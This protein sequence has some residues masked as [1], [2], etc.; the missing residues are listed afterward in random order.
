MSYFQGCFSFTVAVAFF[1]IFTECFFG[2]VMPK[3]SNGAG[4]EGE[5]QFEVK[6]PSLVEK[7]SVFTTDKRQP[8]DETSDL[9]KKV[10]VVN[11]GPNGMLCSAQLIGPNLVLT[12]AHCIVDASSNVSTDFI[13]YAGYNSGKFI[14][15][16]K[17]IKAWVGTT[18]PVTVSGQPL[19][20]AILKIEERLGD[21]FG[22]F[23]FHQYHGSEWSMYDRLRNEISLVAHHNDKAQGRSAIIERGCGSRLMYGGLIRHT[24]SMTMGSSGGALLLTHKDQQSGKMV[25]RIVALN[26]AGENDSIPREFDF[27]IANAAIPAS[28]FQ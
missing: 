17:V 12:A 10:G 6:L 20:W 22:W 26:I 16:S 11:G 7:I 27:K 15:K 8:L 25:E 3:I 9:F 23:E 4:G 18:M 2:R 5:R 24:C 19:D 28:V 13:Y 1:L 21:R 14:T